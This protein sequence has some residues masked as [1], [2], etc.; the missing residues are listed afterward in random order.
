MA[1]PFSP[2]EAKAVVAKAQEL[3]GDIEVISKATIYGPDNFRNAIAQA[4]TETLNKELRR[5]KISDLPTPASTQKKLADQKIKTAYDLY[6]RGELAEDNQHVKKLVRVANECAD[7][8]RELYRP[9]PKSTHMRNALFLAAR[10]YK[11]ALLA[12]L[13]ESAIRDAYDIPNACGLVGQNSGRL[14]WLLLNAADKQTTEAAYRRLVQFTDNSNSKFIKDGRLQANGILGM[15]PSIPLG[16]ETKQRAI[17]VIADD[18]GENLFAADAKPNRDE[19]E[20]AVYNAEGKIPGSA[21]SKLEK[22]LDA[23]SPRSA[24]KQTRFA[25]PM[26][27]A[28]FPSNRPTP[29]RTWFQAFASSASRMLG[30]RRSARSY[31]KEDLALK[32]SLWKA[33]GYA[34][35]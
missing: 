33:I 14:R 3:L 1:R 12:E 2:S 25:T 5:I 23:A 30:I 31:M 18:A 34:P 19:I 6:C 28:T 13:Y 15:D 26:P 11:S 27:C 10:Y 17:R 20:A 8:I 29:S 4:K 32:S 21:I 7:A 35:A 9:K 24:S 22:S 16:P